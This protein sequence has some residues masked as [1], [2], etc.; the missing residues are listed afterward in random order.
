MVLAMGA[1][2]IFLAIVGICTS[3]KLSGENDEEVRASR[4]AVT[5]GFILMIFYMMLTTIMFNMF[6]FATIWFIFFNSGPAAWME[7]AYFTKHASQVV[8]S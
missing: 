1:M 2:L 7:S 4:Y 3:N 6:M 8:S 5:R